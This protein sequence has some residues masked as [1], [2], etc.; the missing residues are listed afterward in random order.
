MAEPIV[1]AEILRRSVLERVE[2]AHRGEISPEFLRGYLVAMF[3]AGAITAEECQQ[4]AAGDSVPFQ[5]TP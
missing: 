4:L 1:T 2:A 5:L 3:H